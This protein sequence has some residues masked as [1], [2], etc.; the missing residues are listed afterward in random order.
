MLM[1]ITATVIA[2]LRGVIPIGVLV[3]VQGFARHERAMILRAL[4]GIRAA[5]RRF[6][7]SKMSFCLGRTGL[8]GVP[9]RTTRLLTVDHGDI[10]F[11]IIKKKRAPFFP[12]VAGGV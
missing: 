5:R 11:R 10:C 12:A 6:R 1:T 9:R 2:S 4:L 7:T 3:T 8:D